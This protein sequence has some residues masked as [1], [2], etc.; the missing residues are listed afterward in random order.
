MRASHSKIQCFKSCRRLYELKYIEGVKY[1]GFVE[2]LDRGSNYHE[3]VE[4]LCKT[5]TLEYGDNP[6]YNA[7]LYAYHKYIYGEIDIAE[8]EVEFEFELNGNSVTGIIDGIT[9]DGTLVEHK[10]T[11]GE[12]NQDYLYQL[13]FNEQIL[14]YMLA[15]RTTQMWY[16]V[17][18]TPTIRQKT[19]ETPEEFFQRCCE[20]YEVDTELKIG[21]FLVQR[22]KKQLQEFE[23]NLD[24]ILS[25]M[26]NAKLFYKNT[27][28]CNKWGRFCEY[29]SI[30]LDY[31]KDREYINFERI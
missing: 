5:G 10:T 28:Y 8:C 6:K 1:T 11:S 13:E 24:K 23:D 3:M 21:Y 30:C 20:W 17:C 31:S 2:A 29:S 26:E 7:M 22:S 4:K 16:T 9:Q 15:K 14:M 27:G 18:R 19:R 12:L 25:E